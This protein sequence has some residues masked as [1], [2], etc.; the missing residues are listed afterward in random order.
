MVTFEEL[1]QREKSQDHLA[2]LGHCKNVVRMSRQHMQ[3]KYA[4]WDRYDEVY[5][6]IRMQ[7][8]E[9]K[10]AKEKKA[11]AKMVVPLG[12]AQ[13]QTFAAFLQLTYTQREYFYEL[14]GA[15]PEDFKAAEVGQA[16][17]QRDLDYN[18]WNGILNQYLIDVGRFGIG[19]I[20]CHWVEET[21]WVDVDVPAKT[22]SFL[23]LSLNYS[24]AKTERVQRVKYQ[25]NK[26]MNVTPYRFF[27]DPRLPM[28]RF[29]E[30]EFVASEEEY[31]YADLKQREAEGQV[32][33]IDFIEPFKDPSE[34]RR[35]SRFGF[36]DV[37]KQQEVAIKTDSKPPIC[38]TEIIIKLIPAKFKLDGKPIGPEDYPVKYLIWYANDARIVRIEPFNYIH[39]QFPYAVGEM[40]PDINHFLNGGLSEVIDELQDT[41][42]WF[43]NSHI[44]SIRRTIQNT[45]IVD[46]SGIV[47]DDLKNHRPV[48]RLQ[49]DASR[50]GVE[51]WVKQLDVRDAT[52]SHVDNALALK[53]LMEVTTGINEN[54]LGQFHGGRRSATEARNVTMSAGSRLKVIG[55]LLF[56]GSLEKLGRQMLSN[57]RDGLSVDTFVRMFGTAA[58]GTKFQLFK[59]IN[60]NDLVGDYDFAVFDGTQPSEKGYL[61]DVL[62]EILTVLIQNP[63]IIMIVGIDPRAVLLEVMRMKGIKYPERFLIQNQ[64]DAGAQL[65]LQQMNMFNGN[66]QPGT[67]NGVQSDG[68]TGTAKPTPGMAAAPSNNPF[69]SLIGNNGGSTGNKSSSQRGA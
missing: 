19:I 64:T 44:T 21:Q 66:Q 12:F 62:I 4:D 2:L 48:I 37:M 5:R 33:G 27:P 7:D 15:S 38:I 43:I 63:Q 67:P 9:D 8:T 32:A 53:Q 41:I 1:S 36:I 56:T 47:M 42:S 6:G 45:L 3:R 69:A 11:P 35:A 17:L 55:S 25:G 18:N 24:S 60:R 49:P 52:G 61:A 23:G 30:G 10:K 51:R 20:K 29:Q 39:D 16:L 22:L 40:H 54:L 59:K 65:A 26:L 50:S 13:L 46:P 34:L 68:Q 14:I 58:D 31:T 57:L 28:S